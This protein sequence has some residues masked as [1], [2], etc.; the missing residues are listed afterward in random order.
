MTQDLLTEIPIIDVTGDLPALGTAEAAEDRLEALFAEAEAHYGR[1]FIGIADGLSR[2]WAMRNTT[3]Y[4][5]E[6]GAFADRLSVPGGWFLNVSFEWSCTNGIHADPDRGTMRM[7]R[8]LDWPLNGL[9]RGLIAARQSGPAG[10]FL[11]ITWPGFAG[12]VT[13]VA[14]G[15]FAAALNQAPLPHRGL[16][17]WGDWAASRMGVWRSREIPPMHLLRQVFERC[18]TYTD[19]RHAL[20]HTP[21]AVSAIYTLTGAK[22][23]EGCVIER[24]PHQAWEH[25]APGAAANHWQTPGLKGRTRGYASAE[26]LLHMTG[27][28]RNPAK[29]GLGWLEPPILNSA[30]RLVATLDAAAGHA[31]LQGFE[32]DGPATRPLSVAL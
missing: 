4:R 26:R 18:T 21:I 30:T 3:P 5:D 17:C 14:K 22:P 2:R 7:M 10:E 11:N 12:V 28:I 16:G 31:V 23:G 25:P 6:I 29:D 20:M 13:A 8:V 1:R 32:T 24:T 9:G 27:L 19:A 15:R